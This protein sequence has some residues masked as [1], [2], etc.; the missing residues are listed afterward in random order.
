MRK[1][2][3]AGHQLKF[4]FYADIINREY[5][6]L[7]KAERARLHELVK[8]AL[9]KRRMDNLVQSLQLSLNLCFECPK[10]GN[11]WWSRICVFRNDMLKTARYFVGVHDAEDVVND[12]FI[13]AHEKQEKYTVD[14][15]LK[16]WLCQITRNLALSYRKKRGRMIYGSDD[17][18]CD[19]EVPDLAESFSIIKDINA[20]MG[21]LPDGTRSVADMYFN[22][23]SLKEIQK[24]VSRS[25]SAVSRQISKAKESLRGDLSEYGVRKM[26][27]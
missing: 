25:Q 15:N 12:A 8:S 17:L 11:A 18:L 5:A 26:A 21:K 10:D 6:S 22:G 2:L 24:G 23:H 9:E 7:K 14:T 27:R 16:G 13:I 1:Q 4:L 19:K 3:P 20:A